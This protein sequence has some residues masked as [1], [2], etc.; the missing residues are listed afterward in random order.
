VTVRP[1]LGADKRKNPGT[2]KG[3]TPTETVVRV[4]SFLRWV[5]LVMVALGTSDIALIWLPL[6][7]GNPAWESAAVMASFQGVPIVLV[8]LTLVVVASALEVQPWWALGA[9]VVAVV[10]L[11][12]VLGGTALWAA[13]LREALASAEGV[14][15]TDLR[16]AMVQASTQGVVLT[17]AFGIVTRH[18]F[19]AFK[20]G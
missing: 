4:L 1:L 15:P 20:T 13:N 7:I 2:P 17:I 3:S 9:G 6:N 19:K 10:F 11:L 8:G 16:K 14:V 12:F 18:A 5:G